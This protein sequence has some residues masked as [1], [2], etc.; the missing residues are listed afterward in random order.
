MAHVDDFRDLVMSARPSVND[1]EYEAKCKLYVEMVKGATLTMEHMKKT[2]TDLLTR[3]RIFI[4]D[5]WEGICEGKDPQKISNEFAKYVDE[6][7][8]ASWAPMF[9]KLDRMIEEIDGQSTKKDELDG[10]STKKDEL[11]GQSTKKDEIDGQS[12]KKDEIDGQSTK[13]DEIDGQSTKKDEIDS[14]KSSNHD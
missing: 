3:F 1:P 4:E 13:K 2:T 5:L 10:Q 12:T 8:Q 14:G 11:D 9:E 7:I 6:Y